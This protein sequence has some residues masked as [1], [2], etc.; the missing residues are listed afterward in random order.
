MSNSRRWEKKM[1]TIGVIP[2]MEA[3]ASGLVMR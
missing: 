3:L 2:K 1:K